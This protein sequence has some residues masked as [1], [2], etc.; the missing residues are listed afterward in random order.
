MKEDTNHIWKSLVKNKFGNK[1]C[2]DSDGT[3]ETWKEVFMRLTHEKQAKLD[4]LTK[5]IS[6]KIRKEKESTLNTKH[7]GDKIPRHIRQKQ[8]K[9]KHVSSSPTNTVD[10]LFHTAN[11]KYFSMERLMTLLINDTKSMFQALVK[12]GNGTQCRP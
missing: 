11:A 12:R 5:K 1:S 6:N 7:C 3:G 10:I 9:V 8:I 2:E 4:F